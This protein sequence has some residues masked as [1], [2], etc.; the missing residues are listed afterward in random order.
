MVVATTTASVVVVMVASASFVVVLEPKG[1][2]KEQE[3]DYGAH[4]VEPLNV[5]VMARLQ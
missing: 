5:V 4:H 2:A 3:E 1:M